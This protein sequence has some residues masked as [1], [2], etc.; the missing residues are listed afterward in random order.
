MYQLELFPNDV[1]TDPAMLSS[2]R[3]AAEIMYMISADPT[4]VANKRRSAY[5]FHPYAR[6]R[7]RHVNV[8]E[9]SDELYAYWLNEVCRERE[10]MR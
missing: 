3:S 2:E 10:Q 4:L 9:D 5:E 1:S 7:W 6:W 8:P